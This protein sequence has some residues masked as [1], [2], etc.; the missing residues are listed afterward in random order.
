MDREGSGQY[1][2][3]SILGRVMSLLL[4]NGVM[5]GISSHVR[6][7]RYIEHIEFQTRLHGAGEVDAVAKY[8]FA[9][10]VGF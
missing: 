6:S 3:E 1:V 7:K 10:F 9:H 4:S 8:S 5:L 2:G